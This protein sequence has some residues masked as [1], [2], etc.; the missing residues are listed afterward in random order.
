MS[1]VCLPAGREY[2]PVQIQIP[3][4]ACDSHVHVFGPFAKYPLSTER[5]Y[6]PGEY[7]ASDFLVHLNQIGFSKGVC[8]GCVLVKHPREK[9]TP[10]RL[11]QHPL[12]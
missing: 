10:A 3:S 1:Q 7:S 8:E 9:L 6:T 5:S 2:S 12:L 4:G 11:T